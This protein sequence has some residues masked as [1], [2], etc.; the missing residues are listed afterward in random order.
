MAGLCRAI[1]HLSAHIF[2]VSEASKLMILHSFEHGKMF[3]KFAGK[4]AIFQ[5]FS[6]I[7][8]IYEFFEKK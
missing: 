8:K 2:T 4:N 6:K 1:S 7:S 3:E 5:R